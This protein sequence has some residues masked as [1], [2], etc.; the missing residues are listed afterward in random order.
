M[1][2]VLASAMQNSPA[3]IF[4]MPGCFLSLLLESAELKSTEP[5]T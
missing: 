5:P 1:G 4:W 2:K 3:S